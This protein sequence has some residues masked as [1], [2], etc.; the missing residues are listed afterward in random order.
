[1]K[2]LKWIILVL[3]GLLIAGFLF[4]RF[5]FIPET[6][7]A[8]P[9]DT[10]EYFEDDLKIDIVYCR[11]STKGREIFGE[12]VPYNEVWRTG[13][14]EATTFETSKDVMI[15]QQQLPAGK[16]TLWS[17]PNER[18]WEVIFNDR[19]YTWGVDFEGKSQRK[20]EFDKV[21]VKVPVQSLDETQELFTIEIN[22]DSTGVNLSLSWD[23][24]KV[25]VPITE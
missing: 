10:V 19:M 9:E 15:G 8:S 12:L 24:T 13:A 3:A 11:P 18:E 4:F 7:K 14:N 17:I 6:K 20:P 22:D 1:M 16:Y 2:I 23:K 21:N 5:Y 25:I